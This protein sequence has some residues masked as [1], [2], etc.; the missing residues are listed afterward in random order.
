M[1]HLFELDTKVNIGSVIQGR[2]E[3]TLALRPKLW[4][5]GFMAFLLGHG[6]GQSDMSLTINQSVNWAAGFPT[7]TNP[8]NDF[9]K[10][11]YD[12]GIIGI[13]FFFFL[14]YYLYAQNTLGI[15]VF[16]FCIPVLLVDNTLVF[17]YHW[18]IAAIISRAVHS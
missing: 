17:I 18:L 6:A 1:L 4:E 10:I 14:F 12:Y 8:H 5:D 2:Q 15:L 9:L 3:T 11:Q 7:P 13:L 16:L